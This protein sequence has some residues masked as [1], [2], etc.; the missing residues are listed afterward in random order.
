M[1]F[2]QR[3]FYDE[4]S[5]ALPV[6]TIACIH[7]ATMKSYYG[8]AQIQAD[9]RTVQVH[10]SR[11]LTLIETLKQGLAIIVLSQ[12]L[13]TINH[14]QEHFISLLLDAEDNL[15]AIRRIF[16]G[17]R[18]QIGYRLIQFIAV[19]PCI[20]RL[21]WHFKFNLNAAQV[22]IIGE[23]RNQALRKLHQVGFPAREVHLMLIQTS[24][25]ENLVH[26]GE[27]A[28]GV[29]I[30]SI[31][32]CLIF[33]SISQSLLQFLQRLHNQRKRRT[34]IMGGIDEEL[35]FSLFQVSLLLAKINIDNGSRETKNQKQIDEL[36]PNGKIPRCQHIQVYHL[37]IYRV[38]TVA[39]GTH[40]Y[41]IMSIRQTCEIEAIVA[42]R[43]ADPSTPVDAIL[44]HDVAHVL[45][46]KQGETEH[47]RLEIGRNTQIISNKRSHLPIKQ[48]SREIDSRHL[49]V[50]IL[51]L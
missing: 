18:Q 37:I 49:P 1:L 20:H 6:F 40:L 38:L 11:V 30:Y 41:T 25:V 31:N 3:Q 29:S 21:L 14:I 23:E 7:I 42:S 47:Y 26:Q 35:H 50:L 24:L 16:K 8:T 51:Y 32:I 10:I 5:T 34:D 19:Y 28:L 15:S 4:T 46:I 39:I 12:S 36:S 33:L 9:V 2:S 44:E 48:H 22:S 43:I 17:I 27:Q 13:A 45:I